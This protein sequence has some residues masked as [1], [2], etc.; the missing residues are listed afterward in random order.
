MTTK[1]LD[2]INTDVMEVSDALKKIL[3]KSA[4]AAKAAGDL[5]GS[6]KLDCELVIRDLKMS[7]SSLYTY[8]S[9]CDMLLDHMKA[10]LIAIY[11]AKK[12]RRQE[13]NYINEKLYDRQ[14]KQSKKQPEA[15]PAQITE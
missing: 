4:R 12:R 14:R 3:K 8:M 2:S 7:S 9:I 6:A 11:K 1:E 10:D 13:L 15:E 5:T